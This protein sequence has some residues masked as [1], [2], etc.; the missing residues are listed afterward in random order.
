MND[1]KKFIEN[2]NFYN[3]LNDVFAADPDLSFMNHGYFPINKSLINKNVLF[4]NRAS[5]YLLIYEHLKNKSNFKFDSFLEIGC[6]RG[7]GINILKEIILENFYSSNIKFTAIDANEK[8]INFCKNNFADISFKVGDAEN[9]L[10]DKKIDVIINVESSHCYNNIYN[11]F[12]NV[13]CSLSEKGLFFYCDVFSRTDVLVNEETLKEIFNLDFVVDVTK[14]V[15]Q[16]LVYTIG[17][18]SSSPKSALIK[19]NI[20]RNMEFQYD[21]YTKDN[22]PVFKF[23]VLSKKRKVNDE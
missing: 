22:G 5:L 16:S 3:H 12:K 2:L 4:K 13:N 10:T 20:T 11:F 7:G 18:I 19:E 23:Y 14:N 15:I 21:L 17:L 6:G 8:N 9:F 1:A